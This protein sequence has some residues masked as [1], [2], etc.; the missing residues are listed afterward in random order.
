MS[1]NIIYD[2]FIKLEFS[3]SRLLMST[4]IGVFTRS[5][6]GGHGSSEWLTALLNGEW[7][8]VPDR[9]WVVNQFLP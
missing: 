4:G 9:G 5:E 7:L 2:S 6:H 3:L 1:E 8:V